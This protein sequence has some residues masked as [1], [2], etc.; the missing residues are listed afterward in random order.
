MHDTEATFQPPM[1]WSNTVAPSNAERIM[2][3]FSATVFQLPILWFNF[4]ALKNA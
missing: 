4:V 3:F 1:F 2:M